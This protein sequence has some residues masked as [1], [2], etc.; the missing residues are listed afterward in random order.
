MVEFE[1]VRVPLT[2]DQV[3]MFRR[4]PAKLGE[5]RTVSG[6]SAVNLEREAVALLGPKTIVDQAKSLLDVHLLYQQEQKAVAEKNDMF[7][8]KLNS[9][10]EYRE[11][12]Y[13]YRGRGGR[14]GGRGGSYTG[15]S[16]HQQQQQQYEHKQQWQQRAN[17]QQS[18]LQQQR[19]REQQQQQQANAAAAA[20]AAA[21]AVEN[22]AVSSPAN[23]RGPAPSARR[24][25]VR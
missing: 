17:E 25:A 24:R 23:G 13:S 14:G 1:H 20:T 6:C 7:A 11:P 21:A 19:E 8:S 4:T 15:S 9:M 3:D 2:P 22:V 16:S 12:A 10:Q 5:V 18:H